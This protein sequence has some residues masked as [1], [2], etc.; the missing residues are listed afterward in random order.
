MNTKCTVNRATWTRILASVAGCAGWLAMCGCV[1][2]PIEVRQYGQMHE[3]LGGAATEAHARIALAEAVSRPH[4]YAVGAL[5]GLAGEVTI[6]DGEAY[7]SRAAGAELRAE[8]PSATPIDKAALLTLAHVS[9][10][11]EVRIERAL[12]GDE[13]EDFI[14]DSAR[15][16]GINVD[17]PFPFLIDGEVP[18]L[19]VHVINGKCPMKPGAQMSETHEPWRHQFDH[20]TRAAIVGFHATDS[21]GKLTHPGTRVHAHV[22][23]LLDGRT[24]TAHVER[25]AVAGGSVLRLPDPDQR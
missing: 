25:M 3:V 12:A 19:K 10:W 11:R 16:Q 20:P 4:A 18:D 22:T 14:A 5:E 6:A 2:R 1:A 21:A 15:R 23:F 17:R 24:V 13:L 7:V 8:G 9:R